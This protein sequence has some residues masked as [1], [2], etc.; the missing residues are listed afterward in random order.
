MFAGA[1]I[2]ATALGAT[3]EYPDLHKPSDEWP[4]LDYE[5]MA[6]VDRCIGL[7]LWDMANSDKAPQWN[8]EN[9]KTARLVEAFDKLM[10]RQ[11]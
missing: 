9:P 7:A 11:P 8:R 6:Q 5:D 3:W 2:P 1:G 4:K 10:A